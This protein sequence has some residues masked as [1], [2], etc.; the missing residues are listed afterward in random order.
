[1]LSTSFPPKL[2]TLNHC[3]ER[4]LTPAHFLGWTISLPLPFWRRGREHCPVHQQT[5]NLYTLKGETTLD[6]Q[7]AVG[8]GTRGQ[9]LRRPA[10]APRGADKDTTEPQDQARGEDGQG[11]VMEVPCQASGDP[12]QKD[13]WDEPKRL[14]SD[15]GMLATLGGPSRYESLTLVVL[16]PKRK[17]NHSGG[18]LFSSYSMVLHLV[19]CPPGNIWQYYLLSQQRMGLLLAGSR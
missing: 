4:D 5:T 7:C 13:E 11:T 2:S 10:V 9:Q 17:F 12:S 6:L 8:E 19:I 15:L 18:V 16:Q 1:M 14:E 3:F